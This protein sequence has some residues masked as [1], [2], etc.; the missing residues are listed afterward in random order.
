MFDIIC[1][2][3]GVSEK[4]KKMD[5][6]KAWRQLHKRVLSRLPHNQPGLKELIPPP[7][8]T[9]LVRWGGDV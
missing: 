7:K 4:V 9:T 1:E 3:L 5:G 2:V 6:G 8:T